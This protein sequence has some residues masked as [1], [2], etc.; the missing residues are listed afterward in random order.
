MRKST[1]TLGTLGIIAIAAAA[2]LRFA[3]VPGLA[4]VPGNLDLTGHYSGT[5]SL[6][7]SAALA[8]RRDADASTAMCLVAV[9]LCRHGYRH[10]SRRDLAQHCDNGVD[11]ALGE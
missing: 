9:F 4:Q 11:F 3:V 1:I 10:R 7:N 5:A 6:L 8:G 2:T